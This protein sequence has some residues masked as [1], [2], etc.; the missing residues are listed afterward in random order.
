MPDELL[1]AGTTSLAQQ[2]AGARARYAEALDELVQAAAYWNQL[3]EEASEFEEIVPDDG[4][5]ALIIQK[6]TETLAYWD[7]EMN[8]AEVRLARLGRIAVML[9]MF[10]EP[11]H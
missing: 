9:H 2:L 7:A 8:A 1:R 10:D 4:Q 6:A 5:R 3:V 11:A